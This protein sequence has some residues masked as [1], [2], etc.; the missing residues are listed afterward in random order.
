MHTDRQPLLT[1]RGIG[2]GHNTSDIL[3]NID[4]EV[5]EGEV[6]ALLGR[7]GVGRTTTLMTIMGL[8]K[9]SRGSINFAGQD[10]TSHRPIRS[11]STASPS[12]QK[13]GVYSPTL[14]WPRIWL[15]QR[16][17]GWPLDEIYRLPEN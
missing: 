17:G 15:A 8:L 1:L 9:P 6:V 4:F 16:E 5:R 2:A 10:I 13:G 7:N 12:C 3:Q 11:T 14:P